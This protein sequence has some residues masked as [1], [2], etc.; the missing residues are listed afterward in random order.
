MKM[1]MKV[2]VQV[3]SDET[4]AEVKQKIFSLFWNSV[5]PMLADGQKGH[6]DQLTL[7][8]SKQVTIETDAALHA[9]IAQSCNFEIIFNK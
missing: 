7:K 3:G 4:L 9:S 1:E 2:S 5:G 6:P 8:D